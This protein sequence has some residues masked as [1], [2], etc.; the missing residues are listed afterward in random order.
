MQELLK[1]AERVG[2]LLRAKGATMAIAESAAGGLLAASLLSVPGASAYFLGG[3][4]LYTRTSRRAL[5]DIPDAALA[6]VRPSTEAYAALLAETMRERLGAGWGVGETGAAGPT[7]NRYGD[8][9]GHACI[10]I[11]GPRSVAITV[12]TGRADR[13]EN[14]IAFAAAALNLLERALAA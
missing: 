5:L 4:V 2:A 10:A 13:W 6:G 14:M 12:A 3:T 8:P 9:A 7:G 1:P 11:A